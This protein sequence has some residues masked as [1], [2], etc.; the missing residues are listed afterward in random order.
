MLFLAPSAEILKIRERLR[1]Q[2][3][4]KERRQGLPGYL[5][6]DD[7]IVMEDFEINERRERNFPM[8]VG[9]L[10]PDERKSFISLEEEIALAV[11]DEPLMD[12]SAMDLSELPSTNHGN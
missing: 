2:L 9:K 6:D 5:E 8:F 11:K 7:L 3:I 1:E 10:S 4:I 12:M